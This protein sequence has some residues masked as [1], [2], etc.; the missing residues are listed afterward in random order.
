MQKDQ[1]FKYFEKFVYNVIKDNQ[2]SLL[3]N[4]KILI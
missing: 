4:N 1:Y 3:L 2:I